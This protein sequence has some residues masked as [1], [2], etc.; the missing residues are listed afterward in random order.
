MSSLIFDKREVKNCLLLAAFAVMLCVSCRSVAS[1]Q[2]YVVSNVGEYTI[3]GAGTK[4]INDTVRKQ[5]ELQA[6]TATLQTAMSGEFNSMKRWEREYNSYLKTAEGY[7]SALKA[8]THVYDDGV[9][10]LLTLNKLR[11]AATDNPEGVVATLSMN[12][13]YMETLTE[14]ASVF[15]LL[16]TAVA[17]GGSE[18]MLTGADRSK[19]LWELED[20]LSSFSKKLYELYLSIRHYRLMDVWYKATAGIIQR[21]RADL[22]RQSLELWQRGYRNGKE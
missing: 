3:L 21:D 15:M 17:Q 12:D 4:I 11:K 7:A 2:S 18:N 20:R 16:Q 5:L 9:R 14:M 8:A 6:A 13:L 19:T 10:I 1:A 22:A